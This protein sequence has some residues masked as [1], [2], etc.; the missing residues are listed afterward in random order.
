MCV[1]ARARTRTQA[2]AFDLRLKAL[3]LCP[4]FPVPTQRT[5][6]GIL[7]PTHLDVLHKVLL[8]VVLE[9]FA[10]EGECGALPELGVRDEDGQETGHVREDAYFKENKG[11]AVERGRLCRLSGE[12]EKGY[13][14]YLL[15]RPACKVNRVVKAICTWIR[16]E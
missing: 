12:G 9:V 13:I 8:D 4:V 10:L 7:P 16:P 2:Q 14:L 3:S 15:V 11:E 5:H 1:R 6:S